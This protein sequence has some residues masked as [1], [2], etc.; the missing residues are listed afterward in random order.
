MLDK[1]FL[2][3]LNMSFTGS[4]VIAFVLIA[5]LLL[6]K[7]PK[8][9][10]YALWSV[11]LFRL[12]C[13]FSFESMLSLL[14]TNPSPIPGNIGY[15]AIP[16][17]NTGIPTLNNSINSNL[18][19]GTLA[20]SVNPLQLWIFAG[21]VLWLIGIAILLIYS[22][23]MLFRLTKK[24]KSATHYSDNIYISNQI[25]TAFVLGAFRPKIYL[26]SN[27]S[28]TEREYI[29]LHEQT[30]I[31]RLDHVVK[32]M[33]FF[34][35]LL[36]WFNPLVW[37]AFF[38]SSKDME[39]SCDEAVIKKLGNA[40]KKDYS[41]SLL[42]LATGKK[43]MGGTP[44][45]FG[46]GDTKGRI[47]NVL[48]YKK[49]RFWVFLVT[50]CICIAAVVCF[51]TNPLGY[52]IP[53]TEY[54]GPTIEDNKPLEESNGTSKSNELT[55][56]QIA[57]VNA[58]FQPLL[59]A[60]EGEDPDVTSSEGAL[61][62]NPICHFFTSYY[63]TVAEIDMGKFVY[64]IPRKSY[65]TKN[66]GKEIEALKKSGARLPFDNIVDSPVPF[67]RIPYET[68]NEYLKTYANTS[69]DDMTNMGDAIYSEEYQ[70]FYSYASDF[71]PGT[72]YCTSGKIE[73]D[74][75]TLYSEHAVLTLQKHGKNYFIVS[76]LPLS[77]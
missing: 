71:G 22:L 24:L 19:A 34:V 50:A 9:F 76:H 48:N 31:K 27:L 45:A 52:N 38:A 69:L 67:G 51:M 10:S 44:L 58:A 32:L 63:R 47:K 26:P 15:M 16:Q 12:I 77:L 55:T 11:V 46:E 64:Y 33:S 56:E 54:V 21:R 75:V 14:P 57:K 68:V 39:M 25:D 59:P 17:I 8:I 62:L 72:F 13:P 30:H 18:P 40:V 65:L 37:T 2:Q 60:K 4:F 35:L 1:I 28:D 20:A 74:M 61:V 7:S 3:I 42:S 5:R 6:K 73:G 70:C 23:T 43:I 49:P 36:H 66:D 53:N 29:L 41:S